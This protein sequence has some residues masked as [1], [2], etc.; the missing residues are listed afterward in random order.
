MAVRRNNNC[1]KG[2]CADVVESDITLGV[3]IY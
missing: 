2:Y 1:E 3:L